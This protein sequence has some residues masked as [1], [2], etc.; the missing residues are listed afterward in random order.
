MFATSSITPSS[1]L[2]KQTT[3]GKK[4]WRESGN[5]RDD[6]GNIVPTGRREESNRLFRSHRQTELRQEA[7][8]L[9]DVDC[10]VTK[11]SLFVA[12]MMLTRLLYFSGGGTT[13][14]ACYQ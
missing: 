8:V 9:Q 7:L 2:I 4:A 12:Q 5:S 10:N 3:G 13:E 6:D 14:P 11:N 1:L